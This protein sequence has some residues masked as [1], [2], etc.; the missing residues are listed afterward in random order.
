[1]RLKEKRESGTNRG[2][3]REVATERGGGGKR[4]IGKE[5]GREMEGSRD[6]EIERASQTKRHRLREKEIMRLTLTR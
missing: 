1:M 6:P 5:E 3:E 4:Y 2:R